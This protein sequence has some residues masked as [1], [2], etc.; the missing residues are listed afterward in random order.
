MPESMA[1]ELKV[2]VGAVMVKRRET[3]T[4]SFDTSVV[5]SEKVSVMGDWLP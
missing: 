2:L 3:V 5:K 1:I 4:E